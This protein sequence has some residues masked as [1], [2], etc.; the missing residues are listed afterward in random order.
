LSNFKLRELSTWGSRKKDD[1]VVSESRNQLTFFVLFGGVAREME[2][3]SMICWR[4]E[5]T[6]NESILEEQ[7]R[8]KKDEEEK[9]KSKNI[10]EIVEEVRE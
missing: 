10:G 3:G 5:Q 9:R 4:Q 1:L 8:V 6:I 2:V 7:S